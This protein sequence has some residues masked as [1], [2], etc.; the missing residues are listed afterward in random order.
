MQGLRMKLCIDCS[1]KHLYYKE[2]CRSCD[3]KHKKP[4][5][6]KKSKLVSTPVQLFCIECNEIFESSIKCNFCG[7][8]CRE[9]HKNK[10]INSNW[11]KR[12][13]NDRARKDNDKVEYSRVSKKPTAWMKKFKSCR[14]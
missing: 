3:L 6:C 4:I 9:I 10:R 5:S 1:K 11:E 14:G 13:L 8:Q 2:R 12:D 7:Y